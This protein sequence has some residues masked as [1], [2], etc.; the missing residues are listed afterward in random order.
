MTRMGAIIGG[1][2]AISAIGANAA[3]FFINTVG[4]FLFS[5]RVVLTISGIGLNLDASR[6]RPSVSCSLAITPS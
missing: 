1:L 3:P 2:A 5:T 4:I 6:A